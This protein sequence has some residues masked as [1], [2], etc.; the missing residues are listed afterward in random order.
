MTITKNFKKIIKGLY[1]DNLYKNSFYLMLS[2]IVSGLLGFVFLMIATRLYSSNDIGIYSVMFSVISLIILF[3]MTGGFGNALIKLVPSASSSD[4]NKLVF[5]FLMISCFMVL[6]M[7]FIF[8]S[9]IDVFSSKLIFLKENL[10]YGFIF[11]LFAIFSALSALFNGIF[12]AFR[13][14]QYV[15]IGN[16]STNIG[17]IIL[18]PLFVSFL[19]MGIFY[20]TGI[21]T[22]LGIFISFFLLYKARL[23]IFKLNINF[24]IIKKNFNYILINYFSSIA[25]ALFGLLLPIFILNIF[26]AEMAAYFFIAWVIFSII[27]AF[28]MSTIMSFFIEGS[29]N[30]NEIKK[31][32]NKGLK[33]SLIIATISILCI[34]LFGKSVLSLFGEAYLNS[35]DLLYIFTISLYFFVINKMYLVE[36][37]IKKKMNETII[38]NFLITIPAIISGTLLMFYFGLLGVGYGWLIGQTL[39]IVWIIFKRI[40]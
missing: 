11:I 34:F 18:L 32:R 22:L 21:G 26:S 13:R 35:L 25:S 10:F 30:I 15:L 40:I 8:V 1:A 3:S 7:S 27:T 9:F 28:L 36:L 20:S 24:D 33:S 6:I 23:I 31:N 14:T 12:T 4:K 39:G 16:V 37:L 2:N 29:Y 5:S 17:K 19:Y 38:F